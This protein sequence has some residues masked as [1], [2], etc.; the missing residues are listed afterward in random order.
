[1]GEFLG[2]SGVYL[3]LENVG[4]IYFGQADVVFD[5]L[6]RV[7]FDQVELSQVF[8]GQVDVGQVDVGQKDGDQLE[9]GM[10]QMSVA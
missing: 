2:G 7:D 10:I 6:D 9:E 4:Q 3:G 8:V 1:M 5:D